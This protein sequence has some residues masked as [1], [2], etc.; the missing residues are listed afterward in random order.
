MFVLPLQTIGTCIMKI[1]LQLK[2]EE[3]ALLAA[4]AILFPYTG[5]AWWGFF[6]L[7]LLPDLS[8][9]GYLINTRIGAGLYNIFHHKGIGLAIAVAGLLVH[10]P[11]VAAAGIILVGHSAMDRLFGYG[12]KYSDNFKHTHLGWQGKNSPDLN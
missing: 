6:S 9:L 5:Y 7:L 12:L 1:A 11:A 3:L 10:A 4:A 8:M 2:L